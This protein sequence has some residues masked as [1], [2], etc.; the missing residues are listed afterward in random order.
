MSM[1]DDQTRRAIEWDCATLINLYML[2]NDAG[3]ADGVAALFTEDG[4]LARPTMPDQ[5]IVGRD[6]IL[7]GFRAR[8]AGTKTRHVVSNIIVEVE[9]E[10]EARASSVMLLYRGQATGDGSLPA[11]HPADPLIGYFN[12]RL[13]K[14]AE[15]WRFAERRGGLDFAP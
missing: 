15:G 4:I 6:A 7:A 3:D 12:D 10:T 13:R 9:S 14:T 1:I 5:P 8:P 2:R 11:H